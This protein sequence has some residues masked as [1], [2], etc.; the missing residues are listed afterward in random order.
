MVGLVRRR[1]GRLVA[2]VVT[3][4]WGYEGTV[5]TLAIARYLPSGA[6]DRRF[7]RSGVVIL[8]PPFV[9]NFV[10]IARKS[11]ER[12]VVVYETLRFG[13]EEL[14]PH[15]RHRRRRLPVAS[16]RVAGP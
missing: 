10:A 4:S 12:L 9:G 13:C 2:A 6:R 1:D 8:T 15:V 3:A 14:T 7:G 5:S 11:D 16:R